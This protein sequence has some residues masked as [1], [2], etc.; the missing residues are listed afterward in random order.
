MADSL[1]VD[2][3][4]QDPVKRKHDEDAISPAMSPRWS[5]RV[6]EDRKDEAEGKSKS[7]FSKLHSKFRSS[8]KN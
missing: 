8:K 5:H 4:A 7:F 1:L 6:E 3:T 2:P